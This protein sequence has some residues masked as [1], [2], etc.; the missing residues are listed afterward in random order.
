M[1][2]TDF[3]NFHYGLLGLIGLTLALVAGS[4]ADEASSSTPAAP[5][6]KVSRD[7]QEA[8]TFFETKVRPVLAEKCQN[9]HGARRQRAGLRIDSREALLQG[10]DSGQVVVV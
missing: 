4:L 9:C 10:G 3:M 1:A 8:V 2:L 6:A 5:S 7:D